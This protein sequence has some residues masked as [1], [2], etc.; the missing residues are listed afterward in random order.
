VSIKVRSLQLG[1]LGLDHELVVFPQPDLVLNVDRRSG[2]KHWL[3]GPI[4][5]YVIEHPDGLLLWDTG[6]SPEWPAEWLEAW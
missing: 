3:R 6:I 4:L 2:Q 5:S 1:W